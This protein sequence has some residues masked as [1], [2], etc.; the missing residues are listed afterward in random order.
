MMKKINDMEKSSRKLAYI[1]RHDKQSLPEMEIGGWLPI[2]YLIKNKGFTADAIEV[3]VNTD[4]KHRFEYSKSGHKVRAIYGHSLNINLSLIPTAPPMFLWHGTATKAFASLVEEG[5]I[6][7]SRQYVHL[8]NDIEV[9]MD[10]GARHGDPVAVLVAAGKM[11]EDG[12]VFFRVSDH[13]WLTQ[14]VPKHYV[15]NQYPSIDV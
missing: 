8:T 5:I 2:E 9:A 7:R 10:T 11:Y 3:L 4:S 6:P 14:K 12:Y 1:L 13:I 15:V